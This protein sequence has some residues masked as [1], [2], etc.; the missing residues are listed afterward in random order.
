ML[1]YKS[2][3]YIKLFSSSSGVIAARAAFTWRSCLLN[4]YTL[5]VFRIAFIELEI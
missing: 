3:P 4:T 5:V 1:T 2:V